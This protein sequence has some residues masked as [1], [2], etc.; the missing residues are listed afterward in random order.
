M[1]NG[2]AAD[3]ARKAR[4]KAEDAKYMWGDS[5]RLANKIAKTATGKSLT[6]DEQSRAG[7]IIQNRRMLD[8]GKTAA[9]ASFIERRTA[10]NAATERMNA[11][12]GGGAPKKQA[13][14]VTTKP[15]APVKAKVALPKEGRANMSKPAPKAPTKKTGKK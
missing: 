7:K 6:M 10:K 3:K 15:T 1:A 12:V 11:A 2:S 13:P 4:S 8:T 9:R 5:E 14:K